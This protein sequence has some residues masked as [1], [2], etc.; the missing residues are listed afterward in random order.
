MNLKYCLTGIL[1]LFLKSDAQEIKPLTIGDK[2]PDV[3]IK[4]IYNYPALQSSL[5][6][7]NTKLLILDFMATNCSSCIKALPSFD[8]LQKKYGD[9]IQVLLV[10]NQKSEK[11]KAFLKLHKELQFPFIA[12]DTV[13]HALFPHTFI[14][15]EVWIKDGVVKAITLPEYVISKNIETLLSGNKINWPVKKDIPDY[16]YNK[17][18]ISFNNR[19]SGNNFSINTYTTFL[20]NILNVPPRFTETKDSSNN[21]IRLSIINHPIIELYLFSRKEFNF[22]TS[23]IILEI[24]DRDRFVYNTVTYPDVW[25]RENTYCFE[26]V[27]PLTTSPEKRLEVIQDAIDKYFHIN[28]RFEKRKVQCLVLKK[29]GTLN[30]LNKYTIAEPKNNNL[31]KVSLDQLVYTL[32]HTLYGTPVIDETGLD[33]RSKIFL[34]A[35][36]PDNIP[37]LQKELKNYGMELSCEEREERMFVITEKNL[38]H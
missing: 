21:T 25:M 32:N 8:A 18:L 6:A 16:D 26:S 12:E 31:K 22:P 33:T 36:F 30:T 23:Q 13:L 5:S 37:A 34:D 7:F 2:V 9:K 19:G 38:N 15:H 3:T 27:M 35:D 24:K 1:C 29:K 20:K 10:T 17:P 4:N 11:V 14:S 28:G